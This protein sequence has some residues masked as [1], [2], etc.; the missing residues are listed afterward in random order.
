[1]RN[2]AVERISDQLKL[3]LHHQNLLISIIEPLQIK[4]SSDLKSHP[5]I[6]TV[7]ITIIVCKFGF[8]PELF[9][10]STLVQSF[11]M[12]LPPP[13]AIFDLV[14]ASAIMNILMLVG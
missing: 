1:M 12:F 14:G 4:A 10:K 9:Y 3:E 2:A 11:L 6:G 7:H 8:L 13:T 5:V